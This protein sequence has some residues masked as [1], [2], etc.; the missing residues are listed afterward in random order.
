MK[1][2]FEL[3]YKRNLFIYSAGPTVHCYN[4]RQIGR[5]G[6]FLVVTFVRKTLL[7]CLKNGGYI[8]STVL[9]LMLCRVSSVDLYILHCI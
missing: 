4:F 5:E 9:L 1:A 2:L 3:A 7:M 8:V 6:L